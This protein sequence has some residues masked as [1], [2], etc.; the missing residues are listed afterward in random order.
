MSGGGGSVGLGPS[1]G[2][3]VGARYGVDV[4]GPFGLE[5]VASWYKSTRDVID[6][7]RPEADR[8]I[9]K[10]DVSILTVDGRLRFGLTGQRTWHGLSPA[11]YA[12]AGVAFD[13]APTPPEDEL[14][15]SDQRY[16][17][18]V[19]MTGVLG[20]G[21]RWMVSDRVLVR[22]DANLALWQIRAPDGFFSTSLNLGAI[23]RSEWVNNGTVS[24][25][26]AY[27]F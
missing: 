9:G 4:S 17:F 26:L 14:L 12:G 7:R 24:F 10:A 25:G 13:V 22:G 27:R 20:T 8:S 1:G 16:D 11:V 15:A 2:T 5:G 18:G 23:P 3:I 19:R 6:P 21:V